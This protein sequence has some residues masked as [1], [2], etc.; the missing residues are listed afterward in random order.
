MGGFSNDSP[1]DA[2]E[3]W[4]IAQPAAQRNRAQ[5]LTARKHQA[6]RHLNSSA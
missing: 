3:M 5:W 4:L 1:K 2:R 6:L